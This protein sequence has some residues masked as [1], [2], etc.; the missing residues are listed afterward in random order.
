M[1]LPPTGGTASEEGR[2]AAEA[3]IAEDLR[4]L[5]AISEQLGQVFAQANDLRPTDFRALT[6]ISTADAEGRP[7]TAGQLGSLLGLSSA[8]ITYLV[9]RMITSGH[10]R[11]ETDPGDRR[12]VILRYAEHGSAVASSFFGPLGRRTRAGMAGHSTEELRTTHR[13]L[14]TV[15]EAMRDHHAELTAGAKPSPT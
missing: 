3:D 9:E 6:H 7:L 11:R 12:K 1:T 4:A 13:V 2:A 10:I 14:Q 15:I 8:A 5:T